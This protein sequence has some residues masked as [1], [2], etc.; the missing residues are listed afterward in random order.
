MNTTTASPTSAV[1]ATVTAVACAWFLVA[2][3]SMMAS[4][5]DAEI[6]RHSRITVQPGAVMP[7]AQRTAAAQP[8]AHFTINVEARRA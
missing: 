4:P 5:T 7:E 1:A 8:D 2:A 3:G 6:A